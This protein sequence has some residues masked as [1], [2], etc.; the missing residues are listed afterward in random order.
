[1]LVRQILRPTPHLLIQ[2]PQG[3]APAG[4][5]LT[6]PPGD[7]DVWPS[8]VS[9]QRVS[10]GTRQARWAGVRLQDP[11]YQILEL[12][13]FP[14]TMEKLLKVCDHESFIH[15]FIQPIFI[16]YLPCARPHTGHWDPTENTPMLLQASVLSASFSVDEIA[17][18]CLFLKSDLLT[19]QTPITFSRNN[20]AACLCQQKL[21]G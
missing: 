3:C 10:E 19:E 5:V 18:A 15:S 17:I 12:G 7:S 1:M 21:F 16:V 14:C 13:H 20:S 2:K 6:S 8:A 11:K 9:M 4:C